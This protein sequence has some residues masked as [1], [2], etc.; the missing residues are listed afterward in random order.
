M[1]FVKEPYFGSS[2]KEFSF[3]FVE[4]ECFVGKSD[5]SVAGS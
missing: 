1:A 3:Y 4:F 2:D 5:S